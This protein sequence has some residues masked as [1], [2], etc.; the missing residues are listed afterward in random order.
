MQTITLDAG[1]DGTT[2]L[3]LGPNAP[4]C[5]FGFWFSLP[6]GVLTTQGAMALGHQAGDTAAELV[7]FTSEI[8]GDPVVL[9]LATKSSGGF[10]FVALS[11]KVLV[12]VLA[13]A[14]N[15]GKLVVVEAV[16]IGR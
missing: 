13:D 2:I 11:R 12:S 5:R 3:D 14:G 6:A 15:T 7:S 10:E 1:G 4:G 9:N 16:R 8:G